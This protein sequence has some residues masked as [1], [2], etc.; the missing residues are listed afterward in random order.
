PKKRRNSGASASEAR[1]ENCSMRL[2]ST[3]ETSA[4]PPATKTNVNERRSA[5]VAR[6]QRRTSSPTPTSASTAPTA[7][8][9]GGRTSATESDGAKAMPLSGQ[10]VQSA[11][12]L[13]STINASNENP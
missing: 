1:E 2:A 8:S 6:R 5:G 4:A 3:S 11:T 9:I 7:A 12:G 13:L 10:F